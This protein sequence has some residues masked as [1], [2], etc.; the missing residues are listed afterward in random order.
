MNTNRLFVRMASVALSTACA[1]SAMANQVTS[2]LEGSLLV[3]AG[4]AANNQ[5]TI[6]RNAAGDV[7]VSGQ[8][9]TRING[10]PSVTYR[11]A[12][13]NAAEIDLSAGNDALTL[14]NLQI[15]N[16]L[17]VKLG[18]GADRL[19]VPA[20]TPIAVAGSANIEGSG[21]NDTI[22][23]DG[24]GVGL[25]LYLDGGI[26][27]LNA[28]LTKAIVGGKLTV[29]GDEANDVVSISQSS[30]A[31][32][33][34]V[35]AKGG[36]DQVTLNTVSALIMGIQTD[37][38]AIAGADRVKLTAVSATEDIGVFTG[39]GNDIVEMLDVEALKNMIVSAD[40]GA[41]KV[42]G[43]NVY[44]GSDLILE[45]GSEVDTLEDFGFAAGIKFEVK[46]FETLLP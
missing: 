46:E 6:N 27:V 25:D 13:I 2:Q 16:D 38:N 7:T 41:D 11:R 28:T 8:N 3:I 39:P 30:A 45:G 33:F 21:G 22:R 12:V 4:D 15:A 26:G 20:T 29:I 14:R 1:A 40:A 17:N 24:M 19:T 10:L 44:A 34:Y 35:E 36:N 31:G 32:E 9:G 18:D 42:S 43:M 5:V 23:I 37:A